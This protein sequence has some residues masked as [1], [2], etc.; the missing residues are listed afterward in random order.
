MMASALLLAAGLAFQGQAP[1]TP[2]PTDALAQ[3]YYLFLQGRALEDA[4]DV[5]GAIA[6]YRHAIAL[7]PKAAELHAELSA[8]Y[9]R[10]G[11]ITEAETEAHAALAL[12][13]SDPEAN[14][15]IGLI[16]AD[17]VDRTAHAADAS[18][19]AADAITHLEYVLADGRRDPAVELTLGRLYVT[20]GR[21]T[22]AT[23]T[24]HN[25]LLEQP[26]NT[27]AE[28][29]LA[30]AY[31]SSGQTPEAIGVLEDAVAER[32]GQT[33]LRSWLAGLYE[34]VG[35]WKDAA[36]AWGELARRNPRSADYPIRQA[37]ALANGGDLEGGRQQLVRITTQSPTNVAAW[38]LL[39]QV[40]RRAG[41]VEA[42]EAAARRILAIDASDPRGPIALAE[43]QTARGDDQGAVATLEPHVTAPTGDEI[44]SGVYARMAADLAAALQQSGQNARAVQMLEQARKKAPDDADVE[45]SLA[46]AY[47]RDARQDQAE[48]TFRDLIA[49]DPT[50]ADALNYLGYMLADHDQKVPEALALIKRALAIAPDNPSYLDSLGWAYVKLSDLDEARAPLERAAAALPKVSVIQDHL[51][52]LYFRLKRYK[53]AAEAWDRALAGDRQDIDVTAIT[54]KRDRARQL[55][56]KE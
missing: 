55:A 14:R 1:A 28:M 49:R 40:D 43:A 9:A 23:T 56:G 41:D 37:G 47:D 6:A 52:E 36:A 50:N 15:I 54:K 19:L 44:S 20:A 27:E 30:Q 51:G 5:P 33:Q 42:A 29:L 4:G 26:G 17:A 12:D 13:S 24:L 18:K 25:F 10:Q 38:Y 35:R 21:D 48:Q 22:K 53:D 32:P 16:Q 3:A 46:A 8:L 2:S 7:E 31:D 39:S 11:Q 45:F 34:K